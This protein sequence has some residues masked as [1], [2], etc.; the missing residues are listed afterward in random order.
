VA[1]DRAQLRIHV[2]PA[3]L[4]PTV[5]IDRTHLE[6]IVLNLV[7]NAG[8][9]MVAAGHV[10]VWLEQRDDVVVLR[11]VDDGPGLD[12]AVAA[13]VFEPFFTTKAGHGGTGLGLS[14]VYSIVTSADGTITLTSEPGHGATFEIVFPRAA[15]PAPAPAA[16]P[17]AAVV[18]PTEETILLVEDDPSVRRLTTAVLQQHGYR[19]ISAGDAEEAT[20]LFLEHRA[21]IGLLL[22]D[23]MLPGRSGPQLAAELL[24]QR[25]ELPVLFLSGYAEGPLSEH[26]RLPAGTR[27]LGKPFRSDD[28][29]RE[30]HEA[31]TGGG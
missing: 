14:T 21:D 28:L 7:V 30:V 17:P 26:G 19:V 1:G 10:D 18:D 16:P 27:F 4:S 23:V 22:S 31:V 29:I 13:H 5:R 25:P 12:P 3:G 15:P 11:V 20:S 24:R 6:Q 8:E 2:A 9:A